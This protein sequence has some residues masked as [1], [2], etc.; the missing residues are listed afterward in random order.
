MFVNNDNSK[1]TFSYSAKGIFND[2]CLMSAYMTKNI[3][4]DASAVV[5]ELII[6]DDEKEL[7]DVCLKQAL[8]NIYEVM[9]KMSFGINDAFNDNVNVPAKEST[10]LQREKGT[11]IDISM[12]NNHAYNENVLSIVDAT[13]AD[14]IKYGVLAE[15][16]SMCINIELQKI[17][18]SKF[19]NSLSQLKNRLFQ[20]KKKAVSSQ[21][22]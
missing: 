15:F 8:P 22:L 2:V 20:L 16:Y 4:K 10:G 17:A 6:T 13:I 11:Y 5:D 7:Y 19:N 3:S 18:Q 9:I 14:C 21:I 12:L 1:I